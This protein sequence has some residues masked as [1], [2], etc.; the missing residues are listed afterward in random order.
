MQG[1][2]PTYPV[3]ASFL[4]G[5]FLLHIPCWLHFLF[6]FVFYYLGSFS[7]TSRDGF[8][9]FSG[10]FSF[11]SRAGFIFMHGDSPTHL[12]LASF[13][14]GE[15]LLHIP[16]CIHF[17]LFFRG[18]C[19]THPVLASIL[20]GEFLL[21]IPCWFHF[22]LGS[23]SY[24]PRAGIIFILF[25]ILLLFS[26]EFLLHV[27]CWFYSIFWEFLFHIPSWLHFYAGSFSYT[28]R[29][30]FIFIWGVSLTHP[31]LQSF[32]SGEFL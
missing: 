3:L 30:S 7:Y 20:C 27:P 22:Y 11:T 8:I 4:S 32:F 18:V 24:T 16:C 6:Y 10:S 15:F 21:H 28:S 19:L 2:S 5:E 31:L 23:F 9:Q 1:V 26:R 29:A 25:F 13:L 14:S 12:V 17:F